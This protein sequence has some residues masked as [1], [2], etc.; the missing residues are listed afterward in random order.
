ML[1]G[2]SG[3]QWPCT[4][5]SP[6]GT[7]RIYVDGA[8]WADP[9]YCESYGRD[10]VTGAPL[11]PAEYKAMNPEGRAILKAAD[12]YPA[13]EVPTEKF[14]LHV[15]TGRTLYHLHTRTKTGRA[16]E[17]QRA[18][19][20]VWAEISAADAETAGIAEGD[21]LRLITPRGAVQAGAR[22]TG[23]RA[24]VVFLPFHYGYWD[25]PG[26]FEPAGGADGT[27]ANELTM[28]DW[29]PASKKPLFKTAAGRIE[30][31]AR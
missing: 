6:D 1:R 25:G 16:P 10:L 13:H 4:E 15:F 17:L 24:G 11:E 5:D 2:G 12:Y 18:A 23:I 29:D 22:I 7:E 14:P 31:I 27:A 9:E 28:T 19:P 8:F 26:G 20:E 30:R 21:P 3:I